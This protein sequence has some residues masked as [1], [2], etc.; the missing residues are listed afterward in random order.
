[1]GC[2][3]MKHGGLHFGYWFLKYKANDETRSKMGNVLEQGVMP[4]FLHFVFFYFFLVFAK[5]YITHHQCT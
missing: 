2:I 5:M 1:M 4:F 3:D